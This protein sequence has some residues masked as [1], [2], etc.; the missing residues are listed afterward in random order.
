MTLLASAFVLGGVAAGAYG[1]RWILLRVSSPAIRQR[2]I[3]LAV[4]VLPIPAWFLAFPNQVAMHAWFMDRII[5]WVIAAG[6]S[7]FLL[8]IAARYRP[9][10][11]ADGSE[12]PGGAADA[13]RSACS[14]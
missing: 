10:S 6:F 1:L 14:A 2:A 3:L 5:V 9:G 8:A 4:S 13:N 12:L 7:V 11:A